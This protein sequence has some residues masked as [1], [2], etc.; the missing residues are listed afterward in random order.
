MR[1]IEARTMQTGHDVQKRI[2]QMKLDCNDNDE[3][4]LLIYVI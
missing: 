1:V 3:I 2:Y 4:E